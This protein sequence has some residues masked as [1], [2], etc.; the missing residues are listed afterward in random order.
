MAGKSQLETVQTNMIVVPDS[1]GMSWKVRQCLTPVP[2]TIQF[3]SNQDL[4][5]D[6]RSPVCMS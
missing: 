4:N 1:Y 5:L 2:T 6:T 3:A